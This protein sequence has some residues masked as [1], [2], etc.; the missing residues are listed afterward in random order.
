MCW[1]DEVPQHRHCY[2]CHGTYYGDLGHKGC[3]GPP[4]RTVE[5]KGTPQAL[6]NKE[7]PDVDP[8]NP[9]AVIF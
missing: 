7:G 3:P 4:Q 1:R 8:D 5:A 2:T 6:P 9:D